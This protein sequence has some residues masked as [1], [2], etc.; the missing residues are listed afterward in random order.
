MKFVIDTEREEIEILEPCS[1]LELKGFLETIEGGI[2]YTIFSGMATAF[3][4]F[5]GPIAVGGE[6]GPPQNYDQP[7]GAY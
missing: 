2:G 1:F 4:L 7:P 3:P 6:M 5:S